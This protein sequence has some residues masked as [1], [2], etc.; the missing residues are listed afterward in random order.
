MKRFTKSL[1]S[2]ALVGAL[3]APAFAQ[4]NVVP[5]VGVTSGYVAKY[6]YSAGFTGLVPAASAT[7]VICIAGS[8][9]KTIKLVRIVISGTAGTL[10]AVPILLTKKGTADTGGTA[11]STTANPANTITPM[12]T[13]FPTATAVL[14]SYT[15]NPTINAAGTIFAAASH[16]FP[17]T[18]TTVSPAA[19]VFDFNAD[20][21][22]LASP[23]VLRGAAQQIC[24]N[25]SAVSI[26]SGVLNGNIVWTEE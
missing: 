1:L 22:N 5:Q 20:N 9:T 25:F 26:S 7:D 4:V 15:A 2:L 24:A 8:A 23:P 19:L 13:R 11:A 10:V 17:T 18:G 12:D 21:V 16:T 14:I 6:T 3:V